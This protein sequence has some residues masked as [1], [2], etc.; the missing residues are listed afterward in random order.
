[1]NRSMLRVC[2]LTSWLSLSAFA[3]SASPIDLQSPPPPPPPTEVPPLPPP[4]SETLAPPHDGI[5]TTVQGAFRW[6][7]HVSL[8]TFVPVGM[9]TLGAEG[10]AGYQINDAFG[11]YGTLAV[12]GGAYENADL[13]TGSADASR[14]R[15]FAVSLGALAEWAIVD[16]FFVAGGLSVARASWLGVADTEIIGSRSFVR[17]V[18][19]DGFMPALHVKAG[20]GI[21]PKTAEGR[22]HRLTLGLDA[23]VLFAPD[24]LKRT[25]TTT[26]QKSGTVERS[27]SLAVGFAPMLFVGFDSN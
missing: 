9:L 12:R 2:L 21:G 19:A 26:S 6:G 15:F 22:R 20:F 27:N 1:M 3:Q 5:R 4:V 14:G 16:R 17:S 25:L 13:A 11:V 10:R 18:D 23:M 8:G 24:S 7:A